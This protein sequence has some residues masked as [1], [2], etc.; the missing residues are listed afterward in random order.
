MALLAVDLD[1]PAREIGVEEDDDAGLAG[2]PDPDLVRLAVGR[3][4]GHR[5]RRPARA[6]ELGQ[7]EVGREP[8]LWVALEALCEGRL[9]RDQGH[10]AQV[11]LAL[12]EE[13]ERVGLSL[14]ALGLWD[15]ER[16]REGRLELAEVEPAPQGALALEARGRGERRGQEVHATSREETNL[17]LGGEDLAGP[18]ELLVPSRE[19][20][21]VALE[22]LA[23]LPAGAVGDHGLRGRPLDVFGERLEAL[24]LREARAGRRH[25]DSERGEPWVAGR[26]PFDQRHGRG[27]EGNRDPER[28]LHQP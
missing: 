5:G 8:W 9:A 12:E 7:V 6:G 1:D 21:V 2:G 28:Q 17:R 3:D 14:D 11:H 18:E 24:H 16:A 25:V 20:L 10:A 23:A 22:V 4:A 15:P 13:A 27:R 19:G 26:G